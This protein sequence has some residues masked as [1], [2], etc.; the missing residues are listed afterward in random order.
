MWQ[1]CYCC[2]GLWLWLPTP[3]TFLWQLFRKQLK[4]YPPMP[5]D[6]CLN[7]GH[8]LRFASVIQ[9]ITVLSWRRDLWGISLLDVKTWV[10]GEHLA[11]SVSLLINHNFVPG[12]NRWKP[13]PAAGTSMIKWWWLHWPIAVHSVHMHR[14]SCVCLS[15]NSTIKSKYLVKWQVVNSLEYLEWPWGLIVTC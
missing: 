4:S 5:P 9:S 6:S 12:H 10:H 11:Q 1:R 7:L 2:I 8:F 14:S 3:F 15:D 13:L